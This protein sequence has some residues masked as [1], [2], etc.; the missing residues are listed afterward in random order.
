LSQT[1][2]RRGRLAARLSVAPLLPKRSGLEPLTT[3]T[4]ETVS[5]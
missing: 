3:P 2:T 4:D 1:L 5:A